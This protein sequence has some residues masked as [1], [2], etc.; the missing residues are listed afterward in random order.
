M[1]ANRRHHIFGD[2]RHNLAAFAGECG[3]DKAAAEALESRVQTAFR[4]GE[5]AAREGERFRQT[6]DV[7][8]YSVTVD[9]RIVASVARISTAWISDEKS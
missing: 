2:P 1:D 5:L 7:D 4:R 3:G 9:G 8:G 6:F